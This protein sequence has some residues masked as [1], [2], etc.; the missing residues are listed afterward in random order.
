ME[1]VSILTLVGTCITLAVRTISGLEAV[2]TFLNHHNQASENLECLISDVNTA[3]ILLH[4]IDQQ[5]LTDD[6]ALISGLRDVVEC[7]VEVCR[8]VLQR[9]Q[10]FADKHEKRALQAGGNALRAYG[11]RFRFTWSNEEITSIRNELS[12]QMQHL[13][14]MRDSLHRPGYLSPLPG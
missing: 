12:T 1:P 14:H 8:S 4:C 5:F 7:K 11:A 2:K 3:K 6:Q 10:K 9:V 13:G